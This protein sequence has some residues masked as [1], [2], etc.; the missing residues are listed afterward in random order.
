MDLT[1][2]NV[3]NIWKTTCVRRVSKLTVT[4]VFQIKVP[5]AG[6]SV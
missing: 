5:K 2:L 6:F 1:V 3:K 4:W